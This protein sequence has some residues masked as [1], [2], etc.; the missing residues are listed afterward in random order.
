MRDLNIISCSA[1]VAYHVAS[2]R[3]QRTPP[4]NLRQRMDSA[5]TAL[6]FLS[7]PLFSSVHTMHTTDNVGRRA[8]NGVYLVAN[9]KGK[10][11]LNEASNFF[12]PSLIRHNKSECFVRGRKAREAIKLSRVLFRD[13]DVQTRA[14]S[15]RSYVPSLLL[16][17]PHAFL[18]QRWVVLLFSF[19]HT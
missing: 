18:D 17:H 11:A 15:S 4:P 8:A 1:S 9:N 10:I 12:L 5:Q 6:Y 14:I 13:P 19:P 16:S 3:L 7:P 2:L